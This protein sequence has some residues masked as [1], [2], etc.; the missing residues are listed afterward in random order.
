MGD[1][2]SWAVYECISQEYPVSDYVETKHFNEFA[3]IRDTC[4]PFRDIWAQY[5][6][7]G[8]SD[9]N[10]KEIDSSEM[11][12]DHQNAQQSRHY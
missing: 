1:G 9:T 7:P 2:D 12:L 11:D 10:M 5:S 6:D 8:Y 3:P 4:Q